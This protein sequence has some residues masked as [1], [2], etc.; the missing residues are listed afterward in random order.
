MDT[1]NV[2]LYADGNTIIA[3]GLELDVV[4]CECPDYEEKDDNGT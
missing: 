4:N 2:V 1:I 3:Q